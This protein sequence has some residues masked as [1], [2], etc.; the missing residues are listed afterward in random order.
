MHRNQQMQQ[1]NIPISG[2][3]WLSNDG[4]NLGQA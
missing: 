3:S 4:E 1:I 2:E